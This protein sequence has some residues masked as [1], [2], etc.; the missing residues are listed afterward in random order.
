MHFPVWLWLLVGLTSSKP[1]AGV[2]GLPST[3]RE[4]ARVHAYVYGQ[5]RG[6][7]IC[8][9]ERP[10]SQ[11][12]NLSSAPVRLGL[13]GFRKRQV[14][15][16]CKACGPRSPKQVSRAEASAVPHLGSAGARNSNIIED[17]T[18]LQKFVWLWSSLAS[19]L[20]STATLGARPTG[21]VSQFTS[22]SCQSFWPGLAKWAQSN[23]PI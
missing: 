15:T 2:D 9:R 1:E 23:E 7:H 20:V 4:G 14:A 5:T 8:V 6:H 13:V 16:S 19:R 22:C 18:Y 21:F 11:N 12:R 10:R 17:P 3:P